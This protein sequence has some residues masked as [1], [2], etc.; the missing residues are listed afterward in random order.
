MC[1]YVCVTIEEVWLTTMASSVSNSATSSIVTVRSYPIAQVQQTEPMKQ[2]PQGKIS[3]FWA[4]FLVVNAALGAGL[5]AF[6][7]SF[8]MT[9]GVLSYHMTGG[10]LPGI[11]A[12]LVR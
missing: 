2:L 6:P 11:I 3:R 1:V 8:Y 10:F 7:L 12:E 4:T 5:L 9:G